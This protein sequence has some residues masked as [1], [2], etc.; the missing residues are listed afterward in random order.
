MSRSWMFIVTAV[1]ISGRGSVGLVLNVAGVW[2]VNRGRGKGVGEVEFAWVEDTARGGRRGRRG[3]LG[4]GIWNVCALVEIAR[5]AD[6]VGHH[7]G[8]VPTDL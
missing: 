2:M 8:S 6:A 1:G 4:R 5:S 7:G 3:C